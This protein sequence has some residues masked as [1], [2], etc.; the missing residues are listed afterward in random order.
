MK[1]FLGNITLN[2]FPQ[3]S[4]ITIG[5][6]DGV[7][8]GHYQ[9][10]KKLKNEANIRKLP[11]GIIIFEPQPAEY[12]TSIN[13]NLDVPYRLSTL[14]DKINLLKKTKLIDFIWAIKFNHDFSNLTAQQFIQQ[15]LI[16]KLNIKYLL[17][18][19]DFRFGKNRMGDYDLLKKQINFETQKIESIFVENIRAS[20]SIIRKTLLD[21][22][23]KLANQLLGHDYCLSGKVIHGKKLGKK[24]SCPTA[25][26][27]LMPRKYPIKGIFIASAVGKFGNLKAVASF[28]YN[29][30]ISINQQQKLEV[31]ILNF[32]D[33]L[34]GELLTVNFKHKIRDE[35]KFNSLE[36]LKEQIKKDIHT[37]KIWNE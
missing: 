33:N 22:N 1:V 7:H 25:N 18:G 9:L 34:Y 36:E 31:H 6:F 4:C 5:N 10:L 12:F 19:D 13:K 8:N 23:L 2:K 32:N 26:I 11:A 14:R 20:S 17:I 21:G 28:G 16:Q 24:L 29:P 3:N 30:T 35:I 37:T 27:F 15:I